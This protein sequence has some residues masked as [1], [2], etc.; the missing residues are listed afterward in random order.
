MLDPAQFPPGSIALTD[1]RPVNE[2]FLLRSYQQ[3]NVRIQSGAT[4]TRPAGSGG[5][6]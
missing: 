1:D 4:P 2:Y 3:K 5:G 6:R